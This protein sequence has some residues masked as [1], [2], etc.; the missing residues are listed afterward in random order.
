[1]FAIPVKLVE[2]SGGGGDLPPMPWDSDNA[3]YAAAE[4]LQGSVSWLFSN[5]DQTVAVDPDGGFPIK[6]IGEELIVPDRWY[7]EMKADAVLGQLGAFG[8]IPNTVSLTD[9]SVG[10]AWHLHQ[11][12]KGSLDINGYEWISDYDNPVVY[13]SYGSDYRVLSFD[14]ITPIEALA[15]NDILQFAGDLSAGTLWIGINNSWLYWATGVYNAGLDIYELEWSALGDPETNT[16]P[17]YNGLPSSLRAFFNSSDDGAGGKVDDQVTLLTHTDDLTY[18]PPTGFS[19]VSGDRQLM[20][21]NDQDY[22]TPGVANFTNLYKSIQGEQ[23][24]IRANH[25][26][27]P[28]QWYLEVKVELL[29]QDVSVFNMAGVGLT[30][31]SVLLDDS[32]F[33][34]SIANTWGVYRRADDS[35]NFGVTWD[36]NT[37][38]GPPVV[39]AVGNFELRL[40]STNGVDLLE[41]IEPDDVLQFAGDQTT[42]D[43]WIGLNGN[44]LYSGVEVNSV[45]EW[46]LGDPET[47][48]NPVFTDVPSEPFVFSKGGI[49]GGQQTGL[50]TFTLLTHTDDLIYVPPTGFS[51]VSGD[52][53]ITYQND[54]RDR[55][56]MP[57]SQPTQHGLLGVLGL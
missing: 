8:I 33:S 40:L 16:A 41:D 3:W 56:I 46:S 6:A 31:D 29:L 35:Y 37:Y 10:D 14:G 30:T 17:V 7:F 9:A 20:I 53:N 55:T 48:A 22:F 43:L 23:V 4:I 1:M 34:E 36:N 44:W 28:N 32:D 13:A 38:Y 57:I 18:T 24:A 15:N 45:V 5:F 19:V 49:T 52:A 27:V 54:L 39:Y 25:P 51:V 12:F 2:I 21:W 11:F 50:E 47:G 26:V 42:G